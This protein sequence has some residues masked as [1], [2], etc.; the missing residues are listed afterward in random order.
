[1]D[2]TESIYL[3]REVMAACRES[4]CTLYPVQG[5]SGSMSCVYIYVVSCAGRYVD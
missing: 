3:C 1:V 4:I 2:S 5:G